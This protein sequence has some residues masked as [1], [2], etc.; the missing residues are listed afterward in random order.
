[1][2][3]VTLEFEEGFTVVTGETGAG[4]SILL[5]A[6]SILSGSRVEKT[7]IRQGTEVCEVEAGFYFGDTSA[8]DSK[9]GSLELPVCEEG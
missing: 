1:M 6:L 7:I 2:D 9:L 5:G 3:E 8:L 4:K